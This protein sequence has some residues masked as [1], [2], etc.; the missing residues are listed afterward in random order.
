MS[1]NL[2]KDAETSA[3]TRRE[4]PHGSMQ[5]IEW[6]LKKCNT[7]GEPKPLAGFGVNRARKDGLNI[8]CR[9]CMAE[10]NRKWRKANPDRRQASRANANLTPKQLESKR[11]SARRYHEKNRDKINKAARE[12]RHANPAIE[13]LKNAKRRAREQNLPCTIT[14]DDIVIPDVC[15]WLGIPLSKGRGTL[16]AGSPTLDKLI[17]EL[18]YVPGNVIVISHKAN[19]IKQDADLNM[20]LKVAAGMLTALPEQANE[21]TLNVLR[22]LC[23]SLIALER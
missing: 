21:E 20:V 22:A 18:G 9:T 12:R 2:C 14:L 16:H 6:G 10:R 17:P 11:Q 1:T 13:L 4:P 19:S 23:D 8:N 15:P 3:R 7:C 5:V